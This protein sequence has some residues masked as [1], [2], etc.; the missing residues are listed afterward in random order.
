MP[1]ELTNIRVTLF[2]TKELNI[3]CVCT[4]FFFV[5]SYFIHGTLSRHD[6]I[7]ANCGFL[8]TRQLTSGISLAFD[9][10][11]IVIRTSIFLGVA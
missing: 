10:V 3:A 9:V 2:H 7:N 5:R 11:P 6:E 1:D 8:E 4:Y